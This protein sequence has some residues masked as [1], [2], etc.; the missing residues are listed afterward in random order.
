[1][2][3]GFGGVVVGWGVGGERGGGSSAVPKPL[4]PLAEKERSMLCTKSNE[5]TFLCRYPPS[6]PESNAKISEMV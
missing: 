2:G 4:T 1:M 6:W 3:V 5:L